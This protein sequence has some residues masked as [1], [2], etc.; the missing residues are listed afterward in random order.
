MLR[1]CYKDLEGDHAHF[2][3]MRIQRPND[4]TS[5]HKIHKCQDHEN[6]RAFMSTIYN[7]GLIPLWGGACSQTD[8]QDGDRNRK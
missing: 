4:Y 6:S 3:K 1:N 2:S 7:E 5:T 8:F